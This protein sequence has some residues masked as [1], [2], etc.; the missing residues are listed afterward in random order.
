[1]EMVRPFSCEESEGNVDS[2]RTRTY[3]ETVK[4]SEGHLEGVWMRRKERGGEGQD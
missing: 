2:R 1:M 3:R 4:L